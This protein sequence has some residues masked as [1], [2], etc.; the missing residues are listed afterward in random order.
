MQPTAHIY[1]YHRKA[2]AFLREL[3]RSP[4]DTCMLMKHQHQ[5]EQAR[6]LDLKRN[7]DDNVLEKMVETEDTRSKLWNDPDMVYVNLEQDL[8]EDLEIMHASR[9]RS[10]R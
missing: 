3:G 2:L 6:Y 9:A 1:N 8:P 7:I 10:Q 4:G 5:Y